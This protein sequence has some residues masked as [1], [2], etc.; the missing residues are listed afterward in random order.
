M[1]QS[2]I[3]STQSRRESLNNEAQQRNRAYTGTS[4]CQRM[5]AEQERSAQK[6]KP[7]VRIVVP[8]MDSLGD[9]IGK[10]GNDLTSPRLYD[11][12]CGRV[13]YL[14]LMELHERCMRVAEMHER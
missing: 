8:S 10:A 7:S 1:S 5:N 11:G 4:E 6:A 12:E 3:S 13:K 2:D 14:S 9:A